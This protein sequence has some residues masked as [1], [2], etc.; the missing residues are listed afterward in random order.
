MLVRQERWPWP[1]TVLNAFVSVLASEAGPFTREL[2]SLARELTEQLDE[3]LE[4]NLDDDRSVVGTIVSHRNGSN[5]I[6][7][8]PISN[9]VAVGWPRTDF[10]ARLASNASGGRYLLAC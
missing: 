6:C 4:R 10:S 5:C 8:Y 9:D 2:H 3:S 1:S 7:G